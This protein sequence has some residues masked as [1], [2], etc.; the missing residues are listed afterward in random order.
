[1]KHLE[2]FKACLFSC[3]CCI[4]VGLF[5]QS[6]KGAAT[7]LVKV[8]VVDADRNPLPGATVIVSGKAQGVV[9]DDRGEV[10]LWVD[11]N[12]QIEFRYVG[13]K[14]LFMKVTKP[15]SGYITL[16][17]EMSE[18][19]Q[20]VVTGYQRTTKRRTT[21]SLATLTAKDLKG[22]PTANLDMLMQ[23]KVA[24]MDVKAVSGRPGES[25]KIRI[26]GT[27]TI[28]GNAEPLWVVDGVPLQRDIPSIETSQIKAGDFNDIFTNGIAGI[29][30]NDIESITILK[31]ASAAA[32]YGSRAAGGVIVVTTKRGKTGKMQINYSTNV[33]VVTSPPRDANLMNAKE[34]LA[35]EQDLWDEFSAKKFT[36]GDNYPVIGAVG[37]IRSGYGQ[38]ADMNREQQ[39]AEIAAL[40]GHS[41]DWFQELF[42]NSVSQSHYLSLSGG[43]EK[44]SYYVS[45]G[46]SKNNGLV[47]KTDYDRYNVSAKIDMKPNKRVKLAF[48]ADMA[49]QHSNSP[50]LSVDPFKY[51][52]FANPYEKV[53]NE[54]GS[55]AADNT[56]YNLTHANGS[57]DVKLPKD[58]YNIFR[59]INETSSETKNISAS[60]IANLSVNIL[61]NFIFEGLAS[62]GYVSNMSDNINSKNTYTAWIDRPFKDDNTERVYGSI[63]QTSAYNTNYNLRGQLHYFN[64]F[65]ED[66]YISALLGT[67][68]RGQYAKSIYEKRY[69]YDPVTG[70]SAMPTY[71]SDIKLE[72]ADILSY[73]AIMD[74]LSGQSI[75]EDAFASFYFSLDYV[76]KQRY[77]LSLTGR[78]DGS[79]NFGSK[80]QFNPTGSLG[81]SWNVDQESFMQAL[82]P[83]VSSLSLRAAFG[84]TGNINKSV[85]PQLVMDYNTS[86]RRTDTDY[87][88]MGYLRNAPNPHLRWEKTRDMKLSVDIGFLNDR[89]RLQGELYDRRTRDAVTSVY[90]PYTTGFG[91]QSYNTSE[92]LNQGVE[93]TLN[94]NV[95]KTRSWSVSVSANMAYNRNKLLKYDVHSGFNAWGTNH[96]GY[97]LG[98]I[99]SGKVQGIDKKLGIYTYEARP[100]AIF[101]T[102][103]DR[104]DEFNYSFYL[105]TSNAPING[106]YSISVS[107]KNINLSLGGSYSL[108]GKIL[109]NIDCPVSYSTLYANVLEHVPTQEN[110]LY[111]NHLNVR[112]DAINRWT[113]DNPITNGHPRIIDAYG[114]DLGVDDFVPSLKFITKASMLEDVSYFKLGSLMIGYNF[115]G[116]WMQKV[117][118]NSLALSF[119]VSNLFSITNYSGIDPETPGAVYPT[120][121]TFSM[122]LSVGF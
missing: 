56:Y 54:D 52:Y 26:R 63:T 115:T 78:T 22:A 82:K 17:D 95:L 61:D 20:V 118:I 117:C 29:N 80:E 73:A 15:V 28:T 93:I 24:G 47:K 55:Y 67:E 8:I 121:R 51:A 97:P 16:E 59:E 101:T 87:Y 114:E 74:G 120:P 3:F 66:H 83:V 94:A 32:I 108:G 86:F 7:I 2:I 21:G 39:D 6:P 9:A 105:G 65:A 77:I 72:Y 18:L 107:Y 44:N 1:M 30:P 62:Y 46:Y 35:W 109:N 45:L 23:G 110:D 50:S 104:R 89:F 100:D 13:M 99:I 88:R 113:P 57:Y 34:K 5:A 79:N 98:S 71:P 40:G 75:T 112:K 84:Y 76:F 64:T 111:V 58:G 11:R 36:E 69:G 106:G 91:T 25:A 38:Y 102:A 19:D 68:I 60:L 49:I 27:N 37:M 103:A 31:D 122:G 10:S 14:S 41:T 90:I 4:A 33:S 42:Q 81:L 48:T 85:Y 116:S 53:Y 43:S 12:T 92:L 70:N 96:V 119:S